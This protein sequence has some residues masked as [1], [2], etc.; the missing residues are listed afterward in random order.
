MFR[1]VFF[2]LYE[3]LITEFDPCWTPLPSV[4]EQL[5]VDVALFDREWQTRREGRMTG[6]WPDFAGVV[7]DICRA[8]GQPAGDAAIHSLQMQRLAIKAR[9]F[10]SLE[11]AVLETLSTIHAA[12]IAVGV[13]SN[14]SSD[15]V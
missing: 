10:A 15:E 13:I 3:T 12:G 1:A 5:G 9:P 11:R 2:D 14:C 8:I 7:R 6:A 4:A